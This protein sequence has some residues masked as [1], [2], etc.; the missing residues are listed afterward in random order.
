M[1]LEV[2]QRERARTALPSLGSRQPTL[3]A[4]LARF[5][6]R[7]RMGSGGESASKISSRRL[8]PDRGSSSARN[9]E[10]RC[11]PCPGHARVLVVCIATSINAEA[12]SYS[13]A[14]T[15]SLIARRMASSH[16][17]GRAAN[18]VSRRWLVAGTLW[19]DG[20]DRWMAVGSG[21]PPTSLHSAPLLVTF[22]D[23][24]FWSNEKQAG[25]PVLSPPPSPI[26]NVAQLLALCSTESPCKTVIPGCEFIHARGGGLAVPA[27]N[28]LGLHEGESRP[29]T[30]SALRAA[31]PGRHFSTTTAT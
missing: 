16:L 27:Q 2:G 28:R 26:P 24:S 22:R 9:A 21:Q 13:P 19:S 1:E 14:S 30:A 20:S 23:E 31:R 29:T 25:S 5:S 4:S 6:G 8:T 3:R 18:C 17:V 15:A 12:R 10:P 7:A 11:T